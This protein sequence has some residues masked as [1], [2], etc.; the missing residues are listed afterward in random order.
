LGNGD[1][2]LRPEGRKP[3]AERGS[4]EWAMNPSPPA[5]GSPGSAIGSPGGLRGG[6]PTANAFGTH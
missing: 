2:L 5:I 4:W 3:G 6:A 1:A